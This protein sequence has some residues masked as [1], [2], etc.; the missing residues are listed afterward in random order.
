MSFMGKK[1]NIDA[2]FK[3]VAAF[4]QRNAIEFSGEKSMVIPFNKKVDGTT[5]SQGS[6]HFPNKP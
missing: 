1:D 3:V 4:A 6:R 5:Y 2:I